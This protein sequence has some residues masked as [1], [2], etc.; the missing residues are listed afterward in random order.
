M[1]YANLL[2]EISEHIATVTIN[3]PEA[4]NSLS[5]PTLEE[6]EQV[7][8][9]LEKDPEVKVIL[10]TGA[11]EK[12][13]VAGGDIKA[14]S[15]MGATAARAF[16]LLAHRILHRIEQ[17]PKPVI[18]VINGYALG[19]GCE[20]AMACDIRLANERAKFSQP[21]VNI[22]IIP[23]WGGTQRLPRLVGKGR[24]LEMLYTGEM[25]DAQEAWRI[26]LVNKVV[27]A[28]KLMD[29]ARAL[30]AKICAKGQVSIR[31]AREAVQQGM[32]IDL[33]RANLLEADLFALC[34]DT[35]DQ[36]EGTLA[37]LEK[38]PATFTDA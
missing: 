5:V 1:S 9:A 14:L 36:K 34:F 28:E 29:E 23:G 26:G 21:E 16:A 31:L 19:G 15:T 25:I 4:M 38:R 13:F 37:F 17:G 24:A 20:L 6:L 10:I 33:Q 2:L 32:E 3:R 27:P 22:G 7:L 30:A 11:G 8:E 35:A 12:A 18:A